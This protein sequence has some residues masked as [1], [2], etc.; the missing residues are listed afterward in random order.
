MSTFR[1]YHPNASKILAVKYEHREPQAHTSGSHYQQ[2][3]LCLRRVIVQDGSMEIPTHV[4][5]TTGRPCTG[6]KEMEE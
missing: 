1:P 5:L 4:H 6:K 3:P 2:C